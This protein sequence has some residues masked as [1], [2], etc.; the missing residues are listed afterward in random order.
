VHPAHPRARHP[1]FRRVL[2]ASAWTRTRLTGVGQ[3]AAVLLVAS[4]IFAID[5]SRTSAVALLALLS[6]SF[7]IASASAAWWQA[8]L[9]VCREL[10]ARGVVGQRLTYRMLVTNDGQ[11]VQRDL[12]CRDRLAD[13]FP[14]AGAVQRARTAGARDNW[15]DRRIGYLSWVRAVHEARGGILAPVAAPPLRPH[16]TTVLEAAFQPLRRGVVE[17]SHVELARPDVLGL[18]FTIRRHPCRQRCLI[19]PRHHAMPGL[20]AARGGLGRPAPHDARASAPGGTEYHALREF[21]PGDSL[22]HVHWRISAKRGV[23]IVKQYRDTSSN[24]LLVLLDPYSAAQHFEALVEAAAS[25]VVASSHL[26]D[27]EAA[28]RV[29]GERADTADGA[30]TPRALERLALLSPPTTD[31]FVGASAAVRID[32]A[33]AVVFVTAHWDAAR[34]RFCAGLWRAA[35]RATLVVALERPAFDSRAEACHWIRPSHLGTDLAPVHL[36]DTRIARSA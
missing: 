29:L 25:V 2:R 27:G 12:E 33:Q 16:T 24:R 36:H 30:P 19:L 34:A 23:R 20:R 26:N 14:T 17:F 3:W 10:P 35:A 21:R 1:V 28:L 7:A 8:R 9:T 11:D 4:G 6:A 18:L 22:R 5:P 32:P 13:R 15:F 31:H